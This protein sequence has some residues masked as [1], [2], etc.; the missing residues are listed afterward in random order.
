IALA[1]GAEEVDRIA[2]VMAGE[3]RFLDLEHRLAAEGD[4]TTAC[5]S[6]RREIE[7]PGLQIR[8]TGVSIAGMTEAQTPGA[9]LDQRGAHAAVAATII[10]RAADIA[11]EPIEPNREL[12][13]AELVGSRARDRADG[14]PVVIGGTHGRGE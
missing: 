11:R 9:D 10:D 5:R 12:V 13:G 8:P 7:C 6:Y 14:E 2:E 4:I 1:E 3:R